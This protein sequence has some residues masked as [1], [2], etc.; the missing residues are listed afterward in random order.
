MNLAGRVRGKKVE[1]GS[2]IIVALLILLYLA[3]QIQTTH[4]FNST[5]L[6]AEHTNDQFLRHSNDDLHLPQKSAAAAAGPKLPPQLNVQRVESG[7]DEMGMKL[8]NNR[9]RELSQI[10]W[11]NVSF[12]EALRSRHFVASKD[13][14]GNS[15]FWHKAAN[16]L[17]ERETF[18]IFN[19]YITEETT[20]VDFG[21]WIGPTLLF[22]GQFSKRSIGMEADPVAY[23]VVDHNVELNRKHNPTWAKRISVDS[24]CI[25][26]PEDVGKVVMKAGTGPG[27]STS[28]I[29]ESVFRAKRGNAIKWE[30]QC[31]TLPDLFDNYWGISRPYTNVFLK[32]DVETYECKLVPSF[33]DWLIHEA[34]RPVMYIS[35]H[36]QI[37]ECTDE[38]YSGVL[39]F[40]GLYDHVSFGG[41]EDEPFVPGKEYSVTFRKETTVLT[42]PEYVKRKLRQYHS[43]VLYQ[44][45]HAEKP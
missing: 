9:V 16:A 27:E 36:P 12:T 22:H 7:W 13:D 10:G 30:V 11:T 24:G 8:Y 3:A 35:F 37:S 1:A 19:R 21:T 2:R 25:A 42:Y 6:S 18:E 43:V 32:I 14:A 29:G 4:L 23:A 28:G 38:E 15:N 45:H 44:N 40:F 34:H 17:W 31:Y 33:Y 39:K 41:E 20:V 5:L 26:R